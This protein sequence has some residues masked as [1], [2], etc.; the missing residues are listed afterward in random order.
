M[1]PLQVLFREKQLFVLPQSCDKPL[2]LL[3][4]LPI[5]AT[6]D[7][8][9]VNY[10]ASGVWVTEDLALTILYVKEKLVAYEEV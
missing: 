10:S 8:L 1:N 6:L 5:A 4:L 9:Q 2:Q 7:T 3:R